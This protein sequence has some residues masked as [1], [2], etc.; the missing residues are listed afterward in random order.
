MKEN[1]Q[2]NL[3]SQADSLSSWLAHPAAVASFLAAVTFAV[4]IPA[5]G[6]DFI[7]FD[8]P[9]YFAANP[10]VLHGL[11][12]KG[13]IWA[14]TTG[15]EGNWHPVTWLSYMVDVEL[16]GRDAWGVHLTNIFFHALN[17]ALVF[18][19]FH[20]LTAAKWRSAF[21]AALFAFHPLHVES[22][23]WV[24]ERK[25]VLS[26]FFGLLSLFFYARHAQKPAGERSKHFNANYGWALFFFALGL[27]SKPMLVTWP[28]V[29][30]LLDYW[31]LRRLG[32]S[33][34]SR[35]LIE[36]IPFLIL[37][38][39]FCA[40]TLW[41]QKQAG[42]MASIN[43]LSFEARIQNGFVSY[44]RYLGKSVWPVRLAVFYPQLKQWPSYWVGGAVVLT[45]GLFLGAL[46][47]W[48]KRPYVTTG[49]FWFYGTL[50][51]V[52]GLVQVGRQSMAD[53]YAYVPLI[54]LFLLFVWAAFESSLRFRLSKG[55]LCFGAMAI[56][57]GC[58]LRTDYQLMHW[59]ASEPLFYHA[60]AVTENN[61]TIYNNL[62]IYYSS[63]GRIDEG[64]KNYRCA[65]RIKPN[66]TDAL[67]NLG[68][69][70]ANLKQ[71][72]NAISYYEDALH[73]RWD[74]PEAHYNMGNALSSLGRPDE[75][76]MHWREA[77]RLKPDWVDALNN[78]AW[79]L[80]THTDATVRN[81][82]EALL[83]A[84]RAVA[85]SEDSESDL[86][87]T[88]AAAYA[89]NGRFDDAVKTAQQALE[90]ASGPDR[91]KV[92]VRIRAHSDAYKAHRPCR[93]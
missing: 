55:T 23:A 20:R 66:N 32:R 54:G 70:F 26:T 64:I 74:Y 72:T 18:L 48:R 85:A 47:Q 60:L 41:T 49:I 4:F 39:I 13:I 44:A 65:L 21:L 51:P 46:R 79:V 19:L 78:L 50:I 37:A 33:T 42:A 43:G 24:S 81:G 16:F 75:A 93:E 28:F 88:L 14:C 30:L 35:L 7:C 59:R 91:D 53:R 69:A 2:I 12:F 22:V 8:D 61:D 56:L 3:P 83:F 31:P 36:K 10:H 38:A 52:I 11:N 67:N 62:G 27:M 84:R 58:A 77:V 63:F 29:L 71:F 68:L 45:C 57:A 15:L 40:V 87:D 90:L 89:E 6:C 86:L 9:W 17:A 5:L 76:I 92:M 80:A 25:D 73:I 1:R 34:F 82:T